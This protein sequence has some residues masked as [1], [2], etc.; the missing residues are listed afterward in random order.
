MA[1][2]LILIAGGARLIRSAVASH[3]YTGA[4]TPNVD[5]LTIGRLN[6]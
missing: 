2:A 6:A 3:A 4:I 1:C 5:A